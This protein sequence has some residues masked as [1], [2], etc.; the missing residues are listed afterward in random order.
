MTFEDRTWLADIYLDRSERMVISKASQIGITEFALI[1]M[2]CLASQGL[3][4]LYILPTDSWRNTFVPNRVDKMVESTPYYRENIKRAVKDRDSVAMKSI[5]RVNWKFVGA[6]QRKNFYEFPAGALIIDEY[7][8][9][10]QDNISYAHDRLGAAKQNIWRKF[11]NPTFSSFGIDAEYNKSDAKVW[12][13]TCPH[14]NE[15]QPLQWAV[16][17]VEQIGSYKYRLRC[18]ETREN[19][20]AVCVCRK[21]NEA[22]DRLS[23]G[24]WVKTNTDNR[25]V[26]G[27]HCSRLFGAVNPQPLILNMFDT[28]NESL[29][30]ASKLQ[31]FYNNQLGET[32]DQAGDR[33][34][35]PDLIDCVESGYFM[36]GAV[37]DVNTIA[38]ADVGTKI[39]VTISKL[40]ANG[41][42]RKV[43]I[44][45]VNTFDD[46]RMLSTIYHVGIGV[47]DVRPEARLARQFALTVPGWYTCEYIDG[48]GDIT[49]NHKERTVKVDRTQSMD[50][51]FVDHRTQKVIYPVNIS[52]IDGGEVIKQMSAPVRVEVMSRG[53]KRY[54]WD[55]KGKPDHYRHA[56]NYESMAGQLARSA[57]PRIEV[58]S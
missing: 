2:I 33:I 25:D 32:F 55:E 31:Q 8:L 38:G 56:D 48:I 12:H 50:A 44:G 39:H 21:C 22:I 14:C 34:G 51:S 24:Q 7:D 10:N 29:A 19:G 28:F 30:N 5:F 27:Y 15:P 13:I 42:R 18:G 41:R 52:T 45:T 40:E 3:A 49:W 35:M 36:P 4:G 1:D 20:D 47:I 26:S 57:R 16:N 9:C 23:A 54:T 11:G 53:N 6:E 58:V 17:V 37:Q 46:L 43:Y